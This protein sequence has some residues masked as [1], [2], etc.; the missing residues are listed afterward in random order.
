MTILTDSLI[1]GVALQPPVVS[2]SDDNKT[3]FMQHKYY[4]YLVKVP[5][6]HAL[7]T[8]EQTELQRIFNNVHTQLIFE[9]ATYHY[10]NHRKQEN[11]FSYVVESLKHILSL[12]EPDENAI[13]TKFLMI[14][15]LGKM[16][17]LSKRNINLVFAERSNIVKFLYQ[18]NSLNKRSNLL[19]VFE[20]LLPSLKETSLSSMEESIFYIKMTF[21]RWFAQDNLSLHEV[22]M[23][24]EVFAHSLEPMTHIM[25]KRLDFKMR[26]I[27]KEFLFLLKD[28]SY[29]DSPWKGLFEKD[30]S[31]KRFEGMLHATAKEFYAYETFQKNSYFHDEEKFSKKL[32]TLPEFKELFPV[33]WIDVSV[34]KSFMMNS[35]VASLNPFSDAICEDKMIFDKFY[36]LY[37]L[38]EGDNEKFLVL[39]KALNGSSG[40]SVIALSRYMDLLE[41]VKVYA[42][43]TSNTPLSLLF[44]LYDFKYDH[45]FD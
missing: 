25:N 45:N 31:F 2:V 22:I 1:P 15:T 21:S 26:K 29:T 36:F 13:I 16:N 33:Q 7:T 8:Q 39:F 23:M 35:S 24:Q 20:S 10:D 4:S 14:S 41:V 32:V 9:H 38:L 28:K 19:E 40:F 42:E 27:V 18:K 43:D 5:H 30:K 17:F 11:G 37:C 3:L 34:Y 44:Q 6:F 12:P